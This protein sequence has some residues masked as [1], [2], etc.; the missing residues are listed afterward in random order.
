MIS[1]INKVRE[2]FK[3]TPVHRF[4]YKSSTPK[5]KDK[6]ILVEDIFSKAENDS[7]SLGDINERNELEIPKNKEEIRGIMKG[8]DVNLNRANLYEVNSKIFNSHRINSIDLRNNKLIRIPSMNTPNFKYLS[9]LQIDNNKLVSFPQ[10]I[11]VCQLLEKLTLNGNNIYY[12]PHGIES[13][14]HL[15]IFH[16]SRNPIKYIS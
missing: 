16:I 8:D 13:L 3:E 14:C 9:S 15:E 1:N 5:S 11:F 6:S 2:E 12:I 10:Q 4:S 7:C